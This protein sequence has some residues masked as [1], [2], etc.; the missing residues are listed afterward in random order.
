[1]ADCADDNEVFVDNTK[2]FSLA[3]GSTVGDPLLAAL[4]TRGEVRRVAAVRP[5]RNI[6][7]MSSSPRLDWRAVVR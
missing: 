3:N 5:E 2:D 1:M 7:E 4:L 6:L